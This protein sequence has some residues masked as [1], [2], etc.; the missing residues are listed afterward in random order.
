MK[1]LLTIS[2]KLLAFICVFIAAI[3]ISG[4]KDKD[5]DNKPVTPDNV[6]ITISAEKDTIESGEEV[7]LTVTVTGTK[8]TAYTYSITENGAAVDY[9]VVEN[10]KLKLTKEVTIDKFITVT[11]TSTADIYKSASKTFTVKAPIVEGKVGDLTS[12]LIKEIAGSNITITGIV[13]DYY[14]DFNNKRNDKTTEYEMTVMMEE[15][16]WSGSF[17][18]KENP[19]GVISD[20]YLKGEKDG[21]KGPVYT[22][23]SYNQFVEVGHALEYEY[24]NKHNEV[25]RAQVKDYVSVP[26]IWEY[27]HLWNHLGQLNVN[28]FTYDAENQVY[29]Y[30]YATT[31]DAYLMTYF[32]IS[33]TPMLSTSE[34][35]V[36]FYFKIENGHITQILGQTVTLYDGSTDTDPQDASYMS[37][38]TVALNITNIGTTKIPAATAYEAPENA[39]KLTTA[40]TNMAALNNYSFKAID[41]TTQAPSTDSSDYELDSVS[42]VSVKAARR[43]NEEEEGMIFYNYTSATSPLGS[44]NVGTY[45]YI[46]ED[47]VVLETTTKYS[48]TMDGK[49]YKVEYT[50]YKKTSD[51]TY[52]YFEFNS[53]KSVELNKTVFQ[54]K[55]KYYGTIKNVLPDFDFSANV[56][57]FVSSKQDG[58][59]TYYTFELR[60]ASITRDFALAVSAYNYAEDGERDNQYKTT[61]TVDSEGHVVQTVY[62]YNVNDTYY[63]YVTTTYGNFETTTLEDGLF[64]EYVERTISKDWKDYDVKYYHPT[65]STLVTEEV[66]ADVVFKKYVK[67]YNKLPNPYVFFTIFGDNV[68]GPFFDYKNNGTD[69]NPEYIQWLSITVNTDDCDENKQVSEET[70]QEIKAQFDTEFA[71]LGYTLD[72]NNTD[73]SGGKTG[74]SDYYL[75]Y[76]NGDVQIVIQH[77][78]TRFFWVDFY[79][80][81]EWSLKK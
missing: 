51:E 52:D 41:T 63:G 18:P 47:A 38:T 33:L 15:G 62:T 24:V 2:K 60:E 50:G 72:M 42:N 17:N 8:N 70:F 4:C 16:K 73:L 75:C 45:G 5:N 9:A 71:K 78:H 28:K 53:T 37:Y 56:F 22:D 21:V 66:K 7:A 1:N 35:L 20:T 32:A 12:D 67:N 81:G 61:I 40:L 26:S 13:T 14:K 64:D 48:A 3:V 69:E 34:T 39:D 46:T 58:S 80:V 77:N 55:K 11:A 29:K 23:E 59:K 74:R 57:K 31:E 30:N 10:D 54:G 6:Q 25:T 68:S 49:D 44:G 79:P 19:D 65:F 76:T 36:D 27:Q 43:A